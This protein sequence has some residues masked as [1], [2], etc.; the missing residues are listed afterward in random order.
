LIDFLIHTDETSRKNCFT[1]ST[2]I[3]SKFHQTHE[4]S[5]IHGNT[6]RDEYFP[7]IRIPFGN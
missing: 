4:M 5:M 7:I 6:N 2:V 1:L 3:G